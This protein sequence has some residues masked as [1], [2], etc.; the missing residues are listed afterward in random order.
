MSYSRTMPQLRPVIEGRDAWHRNASI[1]RMG[2][3]A[4]V[5]VGTAF[6]RDSAGSL[7]LLVIYAS[8]FALSIRQLAFLHRGERPSTLPTWVQILMDFAVVAV[9]VAVTQG[10]QSFFTFIFVMVIVEAGLLLGMTQGFVIA[11]GAATFMLAIFVYGHAASPGAIGLYSQNRHNLDQTYN[12]LILCLGFYLTA[13]VSGFWHQRL[14]RMERFQRDILENLNNGFLITDADGFVQVQNSAADEILRLSP[15]EAIGRNVDD[16]IRVE[17]AGECP[18]RTA[19]RL[20]RDYTSYEFRAR[21]KDGASRLLGLTTNR[22]LNAKGEASGVIVSFTDLTAMQQ[23]REEMRRQDRMAVIGELA[24]GLAH[25][26]RNPV[27]VIRGAVDELQSVVTGNM[28][29][30]KLYRIALRESDHLNEIVSG[31]LDFARDPE[32]KRETFDL[33]FLAEDVM[34]VLRHE[35]QEKSGIEIALTIPDRP[36]MVSGDASQLRQVFVNLAKNA[37]DA[38]DGVERG[39]L[40]FALEPGDGSVVVRVSDT[41]PGIDPDQMAHIF[42][43]FYTTKPSG[44]GMGLAVCLRIVTAHDGTLRASQRQ[45]GGCAMTLT[46][47]AAKTVERLMPV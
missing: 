43:P 42:E 31:F 37:I 25:E 38:M 47:P 10:A 33:R 32:V 7:W 36:C 40:E 45:G 11:T 24:A 20:N 44:V 19:L 5:T 1:L 26:I 29:G 4:F 17:P 28:L 2:I 41:G 3:L 9:T 6:Q 14:N 46:L 12:F 21:T 22:V 39:R 35:S 13:F 23:L 27:A 34:D 15:G 18:I 16:V 8:W 30:E